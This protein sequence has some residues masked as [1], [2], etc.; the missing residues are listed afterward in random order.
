MLN[1][2]GHIANQMLQEQ[3]T[4]DE[5]FVQKTEKFSKMMETE[6]QKKKFTKEYL[7]ARIVLVLI[8]M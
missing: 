8:I 6:K 7:Y 3:I 1:K 5:H 2:S 4:A